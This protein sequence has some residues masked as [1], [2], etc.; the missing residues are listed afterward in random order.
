MSRRLDELAAMH[1]RKGRLGLD[2]EAWRD[3]LERV[4]GARSAKAL[5]AAGR[6]KALD[7]LARL[8]AKPCRGRKRRRTADAPEEKRRLAAKI[9]AMLAEDG[10]PLEY[11]EAILRKMTGHEHKTPLAWASPS[12][13]RDVVAALVY[14]RKRRSR[15]AREGA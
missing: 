11:A 14:D 5:D 4:T 3:L 9:E 7:E 12:Q 13:L 10:R 15:R 2:D 6:A 1:I 8:G